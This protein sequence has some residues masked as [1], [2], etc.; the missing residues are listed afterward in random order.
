MKGGVLEVDGL[1]CSS[2]FTL[3][4]SQLFDPSL[5]ASLFVRKDRRKSYITALFAVEKK[6]E[7]QLASKVLYSFINT[8]ISDC[9]STG[10]LFY[11]VP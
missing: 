9:R 10:K 7:G 6:E 2:F 4:F 1:N 3:A 8:T 5:K 11:S